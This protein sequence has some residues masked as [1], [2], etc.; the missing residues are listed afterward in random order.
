MRKLL[1][2]LLGLLLQLM[3]INSILGQINYS[4]HIQLYKMI[5]ILDQTEISLPFRLV[6][7]QLGLTKGNIDLITNTAL[8]YRWAS[9]EA[10][11]DVREAYLV[12]YPSWGE[13]KLGKQIH[14]WG[15]TDGNN[16]T[17]NLNP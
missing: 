16:P 1:L 14:A 11:V 3:F 17:D 15:A 4:G 2:L 9:S 8:E 12:W 10:K 6:E 7:Y 13:V 5:R